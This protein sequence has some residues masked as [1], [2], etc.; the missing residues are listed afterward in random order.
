MESKNSGSVARYYW[1]KVSDRLYQSAE[2][3]IVCGKNF[4]LNCVARDLFVFLVANSVRFDGKVILRIGRNYSDKDLGSSLGV[5]TPWIRKAKK[6]LMDL[7]LI[8]QGKEGPIE[9]IGFDKFVGRHEAGSTTD[10][11]E[12]KARYR[13]RG[14][15]VEIS[16]EDRKEK[17]PTAPKEIKHQKNKRGQMSRQ[18]PDNVQTM[19]RQCL[20]SPI[21]LSVES[22]KIPKSFKTPR[23]APQSKT[24]GAVD[25]A[26][27]FYGLYPNKCCRSKVA[28]WFAANAPGAELLATM[29]AALE[30]C[31]ASAKWK[32]DNGRWIPNP[33][34][35]LE[36]E[37]W[38]DED[39][40]A[41]AR[42]AA[43][44]EMNSK[45]QEP[46]TETPARAQPATGAPLEMP[47]PKQVPKPGIAEKGGAAL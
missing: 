23:K 13:K 2:M 5:P 28:A 31:K 20:S 41:A 19:S 22:L 21:P 27:L 6:V 17:E 26:S 7:D 15:E 12:K 30:R 32:R 4:P 14:S 3:R 11:A 34:R 37:P 9:I 40:Q 36:D 8:Y 38:G 42:K 45:A 29:L 44:A 24:G 47:S 18:C 25:D 33:A 1:F 16:K 46:F 43:E 35:W 39:R 10:D